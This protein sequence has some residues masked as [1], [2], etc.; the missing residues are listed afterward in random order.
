MIITVKKLK[1][2]IREMCDN[3][4]E[5]TLDD[6]LTDTEE[7]DFGPVPPE[8]DSTTYVRQDPY[9]REFGRLPTVKATR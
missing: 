7:F 8:E 3:K 1:L 4:L 6:H 9:V 2:L 5:D